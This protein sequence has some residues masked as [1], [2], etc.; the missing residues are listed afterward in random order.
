MSITEKGRIPLDQDA[1]TLEGGAPAA[2]T[3]HHHGKMGI[4]KR[5]AASS[6]QQTRSSP[7]TDLGSRITDIAKFAPLVAAV[8]A[9]L[10]TLLDIPALSQN[11]FLLEGKEAPDPGVSLALSAV[12]LAMNVL[13]NS[14]LVARFTVRESRWRAVTVASVV[15]WIIK[16]VFALVNLA[17]YG[18]LSRNAPGYSYD[19]GFWCAVVSCIL[20]GFITLVL[21]AHFILRFDRPSSSGALVRLAGA[22][23]QFTV[24]AFVG[25]MAVE[26]VVFSKIEGWTFFQG[27]FGFGD[28]EPTYNLSRV[29]LFPFAVLSIALLAAQIGVLVDFASTGAQNRRDRWRARYEDAFLSPTERREGRHLALA[30]EMAALQ[31]IQSK[32]EHWERMFTLVSSTLSLV[33]FW[34]IGGAAFMAI[35]GMAFGTSMYFYAILAVPIVTNFVVSTISSLLHSMAA[36]KFERARDQHAPTTAEQRK[37]HTHAYNV[38]SSTQR[39]KEKFSLPEDGAGEGKKKEDL[40]KVVLGLA[41]R[42]EAQATT[43]LLET[44]ERGSKEQLLIRADRNLMVRALRELHDENSDAPRNHGF[45]RDGTVALEEDMLQELDEA[46]DVSVSSLSSRHASDLI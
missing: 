39:L 41:V 31:K 11:W 16:L 34:L 1:D 33:V 42:L 10:S 37:F 2:A 6:T 23:F 4:L 5:S 40:A 20:A 27:V 25:L 26:G 36:A 17:V 46:E 9:P 32:E 35:E 7:F 24:I 44:L 8:L 38:E 3:E 45:I 14:L 13:A 28:F 22:Q 15:C 30:E 43:L 29:L 12:S 21:V 18:A 19:E